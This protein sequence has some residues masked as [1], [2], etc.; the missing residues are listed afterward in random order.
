MGVRPIEGENRSYNIHVVGIYLILETSRLKNARKII[1]RA[2][3][4]LPVLVASSAYAQI[5]PLVTNPDDL[6]TDSGS[7]IIG[8]TPAMDLVRLATGGSGAPLR[9]GNVIK[10]SE[11]VSLN[12]VRLKAGQD[13]SIDYGVGVIYVSRSYRDGDSL[14]V[15]YRYDPKA[16][17]NSGSAVAGLPMIPFNLLPGSSM[18]MKFG[19]G[20]MDRNADGT[21]TR[22]NLW[23]TRNNFS[24]A[25]GMGLTGAYFTGSRTQENVQGSLNYDSAAKTVTATDTGNSSFLVQ[26][27]NMALGGKSKFTANIQ[28]ISKN[29]SSFAAVKE[30][31][32]KDDQVAAFAREKGLKRQGMGLSD[33]NFG[34]LN[35]SA[36]QDSVFDGSKGIKAS[37]Y[38][39]NDGGLTFAHSTSEVDRGF[40][41]FKDL[42]VADW[43]NQS[44]SQAIRKSSDVAAL[45]STFGTLSYTTTSI[46][47]I[48]LKQSIKQSKLG[49]DSSKFGFDFSTQNVDKGFTRYE[50]DRAAFGLEAGLNRQNFNLTKG[51]IGKDTN[52]LFAQSSL[53]DKTASI[54]KSAVS[55]KGK[56]WSIENSSIGVDSNFTRFGSMNAVETDGNI[57]SI[58]KMYGATANAAAER[59]NFS[60][61]AG[62]SR[63]NTTLKMTPSKTGT[64]QFSSTELKGLHGSG[65][66]NTFS[67][68]DKGLKFNIRKLDLAPTFKEVTSLMGFEQQILGSVIGLSRTDLGMNYNMGKKGILDVNFLSAGLG[69]G[70]MDRTKLA[71]TGQGAEVYYNNRNVDSKFTAAG[72][73]ADPENAY[74]AT[75]TGFNQTDARVK[76]SSLKNL[77]LDYSRSSAYNQ[78]TTEFKDN[79]QL[80]V[81]MAID[82]NTMFGYTKTGTIDKTSNS[83]LLAA[84]LER[85]SISRK[86]GVSS[87]SM[88]TEKQEHG[89]T[90]GAG[91]DSNTTTMALETKITKNTSIRTEESNTSYSDGTKG[92]SKTNTISTQL[93]KN[94]GVSISDIDI[95]RPGTTTDERKHNYGMWFDFGKGVRA[96]WGQ[97]RNMTGETSGTS[98]TGFGF[99]QTPTPFVMG[100]P[101]A[102]IAGS[103]VNG[104]SL[105]FS[106]LSNTWDDQ[107]GRTQAFSSF[108]LATNKPFNV[109]FMKNSKLQINSY[110]ASDNSRWLKEDVA[111]SFESHVGR[112]GV[113]FQYRGQVDQTGKRAV[114]R[115]Y[116]LK[117]DPSDKAPLSAAITYKQRVMPDN[118]QYAIR[119]YQLTW[120]PTK[121]MQ[122]TN[123]IQTNPEGPANPNIVLGS[124]PLAQRRNV[125]RLDF[126]G[127]K[128][129]VYGGQFDEMV[130]DVLKTTRRTAGINLS[131]FGKSGSPMGLFYGIEQ[132]DSVAGR[133]SY[134]RFGLTFD[135]KPS[136]NQVFSLSVGNQGWLQNTN[137]ALANK[138]DWTARLNYQW[139]IK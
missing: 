93:A 61:S 75:L 42:G 57:N 50:G 80:C 112:Y 94:V 41:R 116:R 25:G 124:I 34:G 16:A 113:G 26:S 114:D 35:F 70:Q 22:T 64:L 19:F 84:S 33:L 8:G 102:P 119:D 71:Y 69:T 30:S 88:T 131:L 107:L 47:D 43:Q 128:D 120:K 83:T 29:F 74:L 60:H 48:E 123:Q 14:S 82:K 49:F 138:N 95:N 130:D 121:A 118:K 40:T 10:N 97:V 67:Y 137:G 100:Q 59:G 92:N 79:E 12:G 45:K 135:Q 56:T 15:Q 36:A 63:E 86:F 110:M 89:G 7:L 11:L 13:Y 55:L 136:A 91:P 3:L 126:T 76:F 106:N 53:G 103:D 132:N 96:S 4:A 24:A 27:F 32:Y 58:A 28:E 17:V 134:V 117:T 68:A 129:F 73:L 133:N 37:S 54:E 38:T 77:K 111:S 85:M 66:N 127:N 122:L 39:M 125:W 90:A 62:I 52:L 139:R 20:Q 81:D 18:T 115:T 104:T 109:G 46:S 31:G 98:S 72:Q 99:G 105:G 9:F 5:L 21:V 78:L 44:L 108:N 65:S 2:T 1:R 23:G 51:I 87:F 101:L 6:K